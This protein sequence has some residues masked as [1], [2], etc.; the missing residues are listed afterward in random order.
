MADFWQGEIPTLHRLVASRSDAL[1]SELLADPDARKVTLVLPCHAR[2]LRAPSFLEMLPSLRKMVWLHRIVI[3]LDAAVEQDEAYANDLLKDFSQ[4][5]K[6]LRWERV[7]E[8]AVSGKGRNVWQCLG[9]LLEQADTEVI[10]LH[11]C[12]I[13]PYDPEALLRLVTPVA[14]P[15]YGYRFAKGYYA[16]FTDRLHGRLTRLLFQPLVTA[17]AELFPAEPKWRQLAAWRYPLS[18]EMA[19]DVWVA[20]QL[21]VHPRWGLETDVLLEIPQLLDSAEFCQV[22]LCERYDHR[23]QPLAAHSAPCLLEGADD[24]IQTLLAAAGSRPDLGEL[25]KRYLVHA[26]VAQLRSS[27]VARLNGLRYVE[28]DEIEAVAK[29]AERLRQSS[30]Q[31]GLVAHLPAWAS[32][33]AEGSA[34]HSGGAPLW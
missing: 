18:G 23:H 1:A 34:L 12:D 24:I 32:A 22:D 13:S 30:L 29:F 2:D 19:F 17:L 6:V 8:N 5:T 20:A 21:R 11:D 26:G 33:S 7:G 9:W 15:C 4:H 25:E 3:G 10:A 31:Q 16:R 28:T 14:R 27:Q